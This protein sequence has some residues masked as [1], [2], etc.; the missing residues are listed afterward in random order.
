[1]DYSIVFEEKYTET[2]EQLERFVNSEFKSSKENDEDERDFRETYNEVRAKL[3][4][5]RSQQFDTS[6]LQ[7]EMEIYKYFTTQNNKVSFPEFLFPGVL[8]RKTKK[9]FVEKHK[10]A[11]YSVFVEELSENKAYQD[12]I[13]VVNNYDK[14]FD[15]VYRDKKW[16]P[17]D[18]SRYDQNYESAEYFL[19]LHKKIWP[20]LERSGSKTK[21]DYSQEIAQTKERLKAF[22]QE[23]KIFL[24]KVFYQEIIFHKGLGRTEFIKFSYVVSGIDDL[25]IFYKKAESAQSYN[26]FQRDYD[27]FFKFKNGKFLEMLINKLD[28]LG[29]IRLESEVRMIQSKI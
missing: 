14:Y 17:I 24:L 3:E 4:E 1:M 2:L 21:R 27:H 26:L 16:K 5:W 9:L 29:L 13:D 23:E 18:F 11:E 20:Q 28:K 12:V 7:T 19:N 15:L 25:S 22:T 6:S 8:E 10:E